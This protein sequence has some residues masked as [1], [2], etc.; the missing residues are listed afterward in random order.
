M[1]FLSSYKHFS[2]VCIAVLQFVQHYTQLLALLSPIVSAHF[3]RFDLL[4]LHLIS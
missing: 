1:S 2:P 3:Q 4:H